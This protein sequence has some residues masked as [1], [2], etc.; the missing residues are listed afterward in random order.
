MRPV[1]TIE[2]FVL[3]LVLAGVIALTMY[4]IGARWVSRFAR[5]IDPDKLFWVACGIYLIVFI[6]LSLM[7]QATLHSNWDLAVLDN[8]LWNSLHGRLLETTL[9]L[10]TPLILGHHFSPILLALVPLYAIW[11]DVQVLLIA[12]TVILLVAVFPIYWYARQHLGRW[13]ALVW[14]IVF[15]LFPALGYVNLYDFHEIAIATPLLAFAT[16]FL[17]RRRDVPMLLCLGLSLMVKEEI[18]IVIAALGT[19]IF[20]FQRRRWFGL[21]LMLVGVGLFFFLVLG[22]LPYFYGREYFFVNRYGA[23]GHSVAEILQTIVT[24]PDKVGQILTTPGKIEFVLH[25]LVPLALFPLVGIDV[26]MMALP[27]FAYLLLSDVDVQTSIR[28]Q[29]SAVLIPFLFFAALVGARRVLNHAAFARQVGLMAMLAVSSGASYFLFAP[30]PLSRNFYRD[31]SPVAQRPAE[32]AFTF[33]DNVRMARAMIAR[34]PPAATVLTEDDALA[35]FSDRRYVY[36]FPSIS[37]YRRAE[38]LFAQKELFGYNLH[39][40][41]WDDWLATGYFETLDETDSFLLARRRLAENT[42]QIRFGDQMTLTGTAIP[43]AESLTG[44]MFVRPIVFWQANQKIERRYVFTFDLVD[45]QGHVWASTS[46]EPHEGEARTDQWQAGEMVGDQV[47]LRLPVTMP[48]GEYAIVLSAHEWADS[49]KSLVLF[50]ARDNGLGYDTQIGLVRVAKN[51]AA[52]TAN[53]LAKEQPLVAQ[54][55]D[56]RE[57][58]MLGFVPPRPT[59]TPG[60]L[61]QVGVYWRARAKPQGD[62]VV[63]IQLRDPFGKLAFEHAARPANDTYPTTDWDVGEV[64]LDWHDFNLPRDLAPG[65]YQIFVVLRERENP[66]GEIRIASLSVVK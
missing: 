20:L 37:D 45:A 27:S 6:Y 17:L 58:R 26:L 5:R 3:V 7:R 48:A 64:L 51:K 21:V 44:G 12:Q 55:A 22:V 65:E 50:D 25:L 2:E 60:E 11:A 36:E 54:F 24:R 38:Y 13:H 35:Q 31:P 15:L 39:K 30:G 10:D 63:T 57:L 46:G 1:G 23:L 18:A 47:V 53:E 8:A 66:L 62:Y 52:F 59:I 16:L 32:S 29:Y 40:S 34:V 49:D 28:S 4:A 61:F 56:M 33:D 14:A 43:N 41:I 9:T 19:Y 42:S